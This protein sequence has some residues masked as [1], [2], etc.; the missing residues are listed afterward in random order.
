[1]PNYTGIPTDTY[2]N[3]CTR[4]GSIFETREEHRELCG[5]CLDEINDS[6][7]KDANAKRAEQRQKVRPT[8][9][10]SGMSIGEI[11][12]KATALKMSYGEYVRRFGG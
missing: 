9:S 12:K 8:R 4:C 7:V 10:A 11:V 2:L 1:M 3:C 6:I 5:E